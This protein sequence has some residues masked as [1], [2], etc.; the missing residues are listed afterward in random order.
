[1]WLNDEAI[2]FYV[3][4]IL[5][6]RLA[7]DSRVGIFSSFFYSKL[8]EVGVGEMKRWHRKDSLHLLDKI[9][10]PI[11]VNNIHWVLAVLDAVRKEIRFY[12]SFQLSGKTYCQSV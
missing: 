9:V 11:N 5:F 10:V 1:M 3:G 6:R 12:D 2:N 7:A 8:L 4:T